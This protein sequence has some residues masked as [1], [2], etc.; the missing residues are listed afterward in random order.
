MQGAAQALASFLAKDKGWDQR[1]CNAN[2]WD[3]SRQGRLVSEW[4]ERE[5]KARH[6]PPRLVHPAVA[7]GLRVADFVSYAVN[8]H[9]KRGRKVGE[10]AAAAAPLRSLR[11]EPQAERLDMCAIGTSA[12]SFSA[13]MTVCTGHQPAPSPAQDPVGVIMSPRGARCPA[14]EA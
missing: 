4:P 12:K 5:L 9:H 6:A 2:R 7:A 14:V 13:Q 10:A 11:L 8:P 1:K 3:G